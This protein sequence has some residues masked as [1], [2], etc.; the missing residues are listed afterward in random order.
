ML[1]RDQNTTVDSMQEIGKL[2]VIVGILL[3]VAGVILW[4]FPESF[5]LGGQTPWGHFSAKGKF[6][7]LFSGRHLH[8]C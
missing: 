2:V 8:S 7:F 4:R 5:W 3:V 1:F 6:L